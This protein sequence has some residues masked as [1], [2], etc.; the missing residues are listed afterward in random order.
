[1]KPELQ[2][3]Q[4]LEQILSNGLP[5][6]Y[7]QAYRL[8]RNRADAEDAVQDALLAAY[9]HLDQFKGK[10]K[11]SSWVGAIV[12]NS[13]RMQLRRRLRHIHVSLDEPISEVQLLSLSERLPDVRGPNAEDE[14]RNAEL[15]ARLT[16]FHRRLSPVLRRTFQLRAIE[17]L[18]IRETAQILGLP[19]GTVKAQFARARKRLK[20]LMREEARRTCRSRTVSFAKITV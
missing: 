3:A 17:G 6:L 9:S 5:V 7:G 11:M 4:A 12:L 18:T 16:R 13:A 1:M 20:E 10:S 8:L 2:A 15:N 14:Y 19:H